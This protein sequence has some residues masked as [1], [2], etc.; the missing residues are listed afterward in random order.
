ML[1]G[2][3]SS[4]LP[5]LEE[6]NEEQE[7]ILKDI[8]KSIRIKIED[9]YFYGLLWTV[10]LRT[11]RLR[12]SGLLYLKYSIPF[13]NTFNE[14][15]IEQM[16]QNYYPNRSSLVINCLITCKEIRLMSIIY[17]IISSYFYIFYLL[18]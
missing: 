3:L 1:P 13:Y 6:K 8:F 4:I 14:S 17:V 10:V 12:A 16:I 2:L 11:T 5:G 15:N 9:S 18:L 7:R